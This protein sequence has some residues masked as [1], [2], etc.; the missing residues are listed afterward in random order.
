MQIFFRF[1]SSR[2]EYEKNWNYESYDVLTKYLAKLPVTWRFFVKQK[3]FSEIETLVLSN[4]N[5]N[6]PDTIKKI[7]YDIIE[8]FPEIKNSLN[9][10]V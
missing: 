7:Y 6:Q 5:F 10:V 3:I 2:I 4:K 9:T 8:Q 1:C